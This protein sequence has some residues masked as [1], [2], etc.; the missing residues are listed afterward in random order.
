[1]NSSNIRNHTDP[2]VGNQELSLVL[3]TITR[4]KIDPHMTLPT[5]EN[6]LFF[7]TAEEMSIKQPKLKFVSLQHHNMG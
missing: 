3:G 4:H 2:M 5:L 6:L 7:L 1:M